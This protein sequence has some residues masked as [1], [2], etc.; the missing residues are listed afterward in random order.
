MIY[1]K[2]RRKRNMKLCYSIPPTKIFDVLHDYEV[3]G[4]TIPKEVDDW[5]SVETDTMMAEKESKIKRD[6]KY[7]T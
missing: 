1:N 4:G 5:W 2:G 6:K 3:R 7:E